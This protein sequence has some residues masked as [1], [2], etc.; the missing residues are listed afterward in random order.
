[1]AW[2]EYQL[3]LTYS[4]GPHYLE[5][6]VDR[7][8]FANTR[9]KALRAADYYANQAIS[10]LDVYYDKSKG[11]YQTLQLDG[12]SLYPVCNPDC[13]TQVDEAAFI[14]NINQEYADYL[15]THDR[16]TFECTAYGVEESYA[17]LRESHK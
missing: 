14:E 4:E 2:N 3:M 8:I 5:I 1:M 6:A 17:Y 13:E 7:Y 9:E 15:T 11:A 12:I 16:L 10:L